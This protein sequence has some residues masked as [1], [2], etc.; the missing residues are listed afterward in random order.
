[1]SNSNYW[2][3][4]LFKLVSIPFLIL[5]ALMVASQIVALHRYISAQPSAVP[6]LALQQEYQAEQFFEASDKSVPASSHNTLSL[7]F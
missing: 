4:L 2:S 1:M 7:A 5:V 6:Q 3:E